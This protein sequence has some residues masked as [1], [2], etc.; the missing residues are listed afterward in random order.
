MNVF[1]ITASFYL[2][3]FFMPPCEL[4]QRALWN[5]AKRTTRGG[6]HRASAFPAACCRELQSIYKDHLLAFIP[7]LPNREFL[8]SISSVKK[9]GISNPYHSLIGLARI[10]GTNAVF[11]TLLFGI[12]R[13][14][15]TAWEK[16]PYVKGRLQ[17]PLMGIGDRQMA[18][19]CGVDRV[20][21]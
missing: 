13:P 17:K 19:P 11:S 12:Q 2:Y 9:V 7:A 16:T 21:A 1:F 15:L 8:A 3:F 18:S 4:Q 6:F 20:Q 10:G 14:C 5:S